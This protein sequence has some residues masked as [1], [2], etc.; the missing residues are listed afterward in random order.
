MKTKKV[1]SGKRIL[2]LILALVMAISVMPVAFAAE[3]DFLNESGQ[4]ISSSGNWRT[5][6]PYVCIFFSTDLN[7][8]ESLQSTGSLEYTYVQMQDCLLYTSPSPRDC[9]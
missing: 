1:F 5:Q 9:S 8:N 6:A 3:P 4:L 7:A 2:A